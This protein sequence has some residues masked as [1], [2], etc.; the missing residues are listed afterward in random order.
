MPRTPYLLVTGMSCVLGWSGLTGCTHPQSPYLR[1]VLPA[2]D[3]QG[4][5]LPEHY[6]LPKPYLDH[7][8]K[9]LDA[10][11]QNTT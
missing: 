10:C 9:D 8:L 4:Q 5:R 1:E 11:Y 2:Y 6:T 7:L 3:A